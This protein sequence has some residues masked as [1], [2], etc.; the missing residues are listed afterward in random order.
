MAVQYITLRA[1]LFRQEMFI[2]RRK[3]FYAREPKDC[4]TNTYNPELLLLNR[5]NMDMSIVSDTYA[6]I[7][8]LLGYLTK[9]ETGISQLLRKTNEEC[10]KK[11][12]IFIEISP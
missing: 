7:A 12:D 4:L 6:V 8:Y 11:P 3:L 5:A 9:E 2:C 1:F 10:R